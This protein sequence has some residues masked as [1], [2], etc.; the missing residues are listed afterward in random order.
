MLLLLLSSFAFEIPQ[1]CQCCSTVVVVVVVVVEAAVVAAAAAAVAAVLQVQHLRLQLVAKWPL[2]R[3][4]A[5]G[6]AFAV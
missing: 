1:S 3:A 5:D 6:V 2:R 4:D